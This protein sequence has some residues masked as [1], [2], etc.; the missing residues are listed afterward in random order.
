[1]DE[2][3]IDKLEKELKELKLKICDKVPKKE[4]KKRE[5][6]EY[7]KFVQ[8]HL[9]KLKKSDGENYNHKEAFKSASV[10]WKAKTSKE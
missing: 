9:S 4:K 2:T 1:M 10:A 3:R 8:E 6:T 5:P 7:N